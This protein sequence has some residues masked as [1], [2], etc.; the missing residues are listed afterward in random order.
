MAP[1]LPLGLVPEARADDRRF[2]VV[3]SQ[4]PLHPSFHL[5]CTFTLTARVL[6]VGGSLTLPSYLTL[7][8]QGCAI[9]RV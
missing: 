1:T 7:L 3:K 6:E 4:T 8:T 9:A 5:Q 2:R